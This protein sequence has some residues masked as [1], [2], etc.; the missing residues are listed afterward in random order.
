MLES[1]IQVMKPIAAPERPVRLVVLAEV[2]DIEGE[3]GGHRDPGDGGE[4]A[5]PADPPPFRQAPAGPVPIDQGH[6]RDD[7]GEQ[8]D[9]IDEA[10]DQAEGV[11]QA[12]GNRRAQGAHGH[13]HHGQDD[14]TVVRHPNAHTAPTK[15]HG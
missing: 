12:G 11:A 3:T 13:G 14:E 9:P 2:G 1:Q 6:G 8:D 15:L 7:E 10:V 4:P 5:A